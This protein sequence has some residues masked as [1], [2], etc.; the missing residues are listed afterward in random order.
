M[1]LKFR[2]SLVFCCQN[3]PV[4]LNPSVRQHAIYA[5]SSISINNFHSFRPQIYTFPSI[6]SLSC[7]HYFVFCPPLTLASACDSVRLLPA[8]L[9]LTR[10]KPLSISSRLPHKLV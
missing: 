2:H 10:C 5:L 1:H 9:A 4:R 6:S 8:V 7:P 3:P